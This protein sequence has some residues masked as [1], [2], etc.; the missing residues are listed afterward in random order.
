MKWISVKESLPSEKE[1]VL[2]SDGESVHELYFRPLKDGT[3]YFEDDEGSTL[4]KEVTHWMPLPEP[5]KE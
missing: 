5:P 1:N 4:W 3:V 2:C